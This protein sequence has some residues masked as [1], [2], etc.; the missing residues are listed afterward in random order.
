MASR[1]QIKLTGD[2]SSFL[3]PQ[4]LLQQ[5]TLVS[6]SQTA[7]RLETKYP[8][9]ADLQGTSHSNLYTATCSIFVFYSWQTTDIQRTKRACVS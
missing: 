1:K 7:T 8:N 9:G 5:T 2:G 4:S 3:K 6:P